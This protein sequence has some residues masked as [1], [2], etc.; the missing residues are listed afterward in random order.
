M[1]SGQQE[2]SNGYNNVPIYKLFVIY[3]TDTPRTA[4]ARAV[5]VRPHKIVLFL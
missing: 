4:P 2:M 1:I 5:Y 3:T